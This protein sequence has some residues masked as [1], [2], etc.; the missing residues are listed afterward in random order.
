[1]RLSHRREKQDRRTHAA[2]SHATAILCVASLAGCGPPVRD[3]AVPSQSEA[4]DAPT[5]YDDRPWATVV[6]ENVKDNLADYGHLAAHSQPLHDYLAILA[7]IGPTQAPSAFPLPEDRVCYYINAYNA[8]VVAAVLAADVPDTVHDVTSGSIDRR[9]RVT[10]DGRP[11]T[12]A[13]LERLAIEASDLDMRVVFAL[14]DGAMGS[15]PLSN[16]PFRPAGLDDRLRELAEQAMDNAHMV[17]ID[18]ER[19]FLMLS[20]T[21]STRRDEFIQFYMRKT[22]AREATMLNVLLHFAGPV[23]RQWLNTAVGYAERMLP[24]DR[25]LNRW[26]RPEK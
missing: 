5:R 18:H 7:S 21:L 23:R 3:I 13:D 22:G 16:Q 8:A 10:V 2:R 25:R 1:M 20:T 17:T 15:A 14:C 26:V 6:R 12:P 19:Q 24:F 11:R 9:F 4:S